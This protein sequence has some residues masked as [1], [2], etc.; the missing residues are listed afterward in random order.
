MH[1]RSPPEKR[2]N[3]RP[4]NGRKECRA[5]P[6][7]NDFRGSFAPDPFP[8]R[9][10]S[11]YIFKRRSLP[12]IFFVACSVKKRKTRRALSFPSRHPRP[13]GHLGSGKH[14]GRSRRFKGRRC[15]GS[16]LDVAVLPCSYGGE[17][18][19]DR[20]KHPQK[21]AIPCGQ[22]GDLLYAPMGRGLLLRSLPSLL[23]QRGVCLANGS[24]RRRAVLR[25][26]KQSSFRSCAVIRHPS[27][28][29]P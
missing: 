15:R 20:F 27:L 28:S 14:G 1:L 19:R 10:L 4:T 29:P 6:V 5:T 16:F 9:P 26:E 7:L 18:R 13:C 12:R 21:E 22:R 17:I 11:S 3:V 24:L 23:P 2:R 8:L 25:R